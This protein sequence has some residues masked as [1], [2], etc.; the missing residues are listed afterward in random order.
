LKEDARAPLEMVDGKLVPSAHNPLPV[1]PLPE[2]TPC[3]KIVVYCAFPSSYIQ[4]VKVLDIHGIKSLQIHGRTS[5]SARTAIINQ[6]KTSGIDGPRVLV[7]SSVGQTG[8]NLPF[9]NILLVLDTQWTV[10]AADQLY[11][12]IQ[13]YPQLK[14]VHIYHIIADDTQDVFL[15]N[16]SFSKGAIMDAFTRSTPS[17]RALFKDTDEPEGESSDSET[18][19]PSVDRSNKKGKK[20]CAKRGNDKQVDKAKAKRSK[21]SPKD[22][23]PVKSSN[24]PSDREGTRA[25]T[26][27]SASS[28]ETQMAGAKDDRMKENVAVDD[29]MQT[30]SL[31]EG[32][33]GTIYTSS[34]KRPAE[35]P[36][37]G[38]ANKIQKGQAGDHV[39]NILS[40]LQQE[41]GLSAEQML[42]TLLASTGAQTPSSGGASTTTSPQEGPSQTR[43]DPLAAF[44]ALMDSDSS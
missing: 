27:S 42:R 40:R 22:T 6:F 37:K 39:A 9:A 12:R 21:Q 26:S 14:P 28:G 23:G 10:T 29:R 13:R 4:L 32:P 1:A 11:G 18:E 30:A 33:A 19:P 36:L 17:M 44:K 5:Q 2:G 38:F 31:G 8:L 35:S 16:L 7:M 34:H 43:K 3:D 41:S 15:N 25:L 20:T 24:T